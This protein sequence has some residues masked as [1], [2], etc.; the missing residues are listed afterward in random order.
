MFNK[1][2]YFFIFSFIFVSCNSRQ[3]QKAKPSFLAAKEVVRLN[4]VV[5]KSTI[6]EALGQYSPEFEGVFIPEAINGNFAFIV[7]KKETEQYALVIR[8]SVIEFSNAGF[9]NFVMQD[10][11]IFTIKSWPYT[12]TIQQAYVSNG[13][14][15]GFQNLLQLRDKTSGLTIKE[16]IEQKISV[17]ASL[18]ITGHSLGGNLAYPMAGYLS[19]ELSA[20]KRGNLQLITF[21]APAAGNAAFVK[22][23]EE[24]YPAAERYTT[25]KDIATVF[26]DMDKVEEIAHITGLD[27]VLQLSQLSIPGINKLKTSDLLDIAGEILKATKVINET[28]RYV[29]S[30]RHLRLLT[31][32]AA[33]VPADTSYTAES[34]FNR[35]YQFHKVDRY[36]DLLGVKPLE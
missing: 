12:D 34:L 11:N 36:A 1:I 16:F 28:N 7:K 24:K 5:Y 23:M 9:Q 26:P 27:S 15:I 14:W 20:E 17:D 6:A 21:G 25:D 22:D 8:G 29:Q 4:Q 2:F 18:V 33:A 32:D 13:A 3:K 35:A 10:F 30:Q 19:K 31:V